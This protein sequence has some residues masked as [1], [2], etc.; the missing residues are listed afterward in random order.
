MCVFPTEGP[1]AEV[2]TAQVIG[3]GARL[4]VAED[5]LSAVSTAETLV[6]RLLLT[7]GFPPLVFPLRPLPFGLGRRA[8]RVLQ[9]Q[10]VQSTR[11]VLAG[12]ESV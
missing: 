2:Q 3:L 4:L 5:Q 6:L 9:R 1:L 11:S 10:P 7:L 12:F 8:I